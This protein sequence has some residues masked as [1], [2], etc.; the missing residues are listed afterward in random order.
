MLTEWN[1]AKVGPDDYEAKHPQLEPSSPGPDPQALY[2]PRPDTNSEVSSVNITFP[3]FNTETLRY[4]ELVSMKAS[5][6]TVTLGGGV[7]TPTNANPTGVMRQLLV[8]NC[9]SG[10]VCN[11]DLYSYRV[12]VVGVQVN[13]TLTVLDIQLP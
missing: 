3:V 13:I 10:V 9:S 4:I 2:D 11:T 7:V 8:R 6:G 1:G 5:V 12:E